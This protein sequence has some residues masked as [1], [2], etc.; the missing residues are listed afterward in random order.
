M[1]DRE[2]AGIGT[3]SREKYVHIHIEKVKAELGYK[4]KERKN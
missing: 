3:M 4:I 2:Q 1:C